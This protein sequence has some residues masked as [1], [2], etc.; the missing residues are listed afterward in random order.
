MSSQSSRQRQG[1]IQ[2][3]HY[4]KDSTTPINWQ[5]RSRHPLHQRH[6]CQTPTQ[7]HTT[8]KLTITANTHTWNFVN[9]SL[10]LGM[11]SDSTTSLTQTSTQ[12]IKLLIDFLFVRCD[13]IG[14]IK[15]TSLTN[16]PGSF[17]IPLNSIDIGSTAYIGRN[18]LPGINHVF[19]PKPTFHVT[20]YDPNGITVDLHG[21]SHQFILDLWRE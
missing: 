7:H 3:S 6:K 17:T 18:V 1:Q 11:M 21:T 5:H 20:I 9:T 12:A 19:Y 15:N 13:L 14:E 8:H 16:V 4:L 10:L 2:S